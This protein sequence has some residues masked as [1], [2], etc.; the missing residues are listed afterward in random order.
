MEAKDTEKG[1]QCQQQHCWLSKE[2]ESGFCSAPERVW[3]HPGTP[4]GAA[5][6]TLGTPDQ[7]EESLWNIERLEHEALGEDSLETKRTGRIHWYDA[8]TGT[9]S[10]VKAQDGL[11]AP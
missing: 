9:F 4:Q 7:G 1:H 11:Q 5:T 8:A 2:T 10:V 6:H 3:Q